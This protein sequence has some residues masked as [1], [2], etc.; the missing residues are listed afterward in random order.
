[1][2]F[3]VVSSVAR[4]VFGTRNE[5]LVKRYL[6]IV[7]RVSALEAETRQ[8]DDQALRAK[9]DEFKQQVA[10]CQA[11]WSVFQLQCRLNAKDL[12]ASSGC[13]KWF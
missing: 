7:D 9:T 5:R 8:L 13:G 4:K 11:E 3:P 2:A 1:M 10:A 12:P 6:N